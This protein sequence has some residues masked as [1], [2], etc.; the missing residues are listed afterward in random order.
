MGRR[1]GQYALYKGEEILC[2]G[3]IDEISKEMKIGRATV[4][5]YQTPRYKRRLANRKC[6]GNVR[7]LVKLEDDDE[8]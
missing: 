5:G 7:M 8:I 1:A 6:S 4:L 2:I 3:T